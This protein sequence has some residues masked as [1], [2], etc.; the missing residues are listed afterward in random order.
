MP[1]ITLHLH[2]PLRRTFRVLQVAGLF[3][4]PLAEQI[5]HELTAEVPGLGEEWTI[6]AIVGPSGSGKTT[7]ARAAF[8]GVHE[9]PPWAAGEAI[10]DGLGDAPLKEIARV[11]TAVGLGSVPTW[12][13]PYQVL[14]TG[15]RFRA[16]VARAILKVPSSKFKVQSCDSNP[17]L[18]LEPRTV[19]SSTILVLDEFTSTLDRVVACTASAAIARL[20]RSGS[21][22]RRL[23]VLTCHA[24]ILPWLAPDWVLDL[25][26]SPPRLA[27]G[28]L[29]RPTLR[30]EIRRVAQAFWPAFARHHYLSGGL[31]SSAT[32]WGAFASTE[33]QGS[34]FNVQSGDAVPTLNFEPGTWNSNL[35]IAICAVVA[36][37]G[38]RGRK[39]ITR[40][41]TLP[42][43]QGLGIGPRLAEA[44]ATHERSRGNRVTITASHPAIV[45]HCARSP[46]WQYAGL[47]KTGSTR[48]RHGQRAIACS[49]GRAVAS[50]EFVGSGGGEGEGAREREGEAM[51]N[52]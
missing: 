29:R 26:Q 49:T 37:F 31:A 41:V 33:V 9:P 15:E 1:T 24:D 2:T 40:L 10:I 21:Q 43:F 34:K 38:W 51:S 39:R 5:S 35:P 42:E 23:V 44:V 6:G 25:G 32:C 4:V 8:G 19:N 3:D 47:K 52:R 46:R 20:L 16:D 36:A 13:K 27:R 28:R 17:T 22:A 12:L 50:F 30:L 7:L 18:N 14:S 11:L 45:A 48:Q